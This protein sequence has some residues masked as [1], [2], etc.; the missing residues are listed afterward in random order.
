MLLGAA[1]GERVMSNDFDAV[2]YVR[3][4]PRFRF[5]DGLFHVCFNVGKVHAEFVMLPSVFLKGRRAAKKA[6][7]QF[8]A[9]ADSVAIRGNE[10]RH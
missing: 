8:R 10:A 1:F 5:E 3:E 2:F 9:A 7:D 6:E 4:V